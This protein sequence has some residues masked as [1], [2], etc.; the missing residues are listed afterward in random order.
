M[1]CFVLW[2]KLVLCAMFLLLFTPLRASESLQLQANALLSSAEKTSIL[3]PGGESLAF[4]ESVAFT[5][6]GMTSADVQVNFKG[7]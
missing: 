4:H 5:L 3:A 6:R 1:S 2:R 7:R